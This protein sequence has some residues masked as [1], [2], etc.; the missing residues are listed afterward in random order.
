M[1]CFFRFRE[2]N[3]FTWRK[4]SLLK[5]GIDSPIP[6]YVS[7]ED[8]DEVEEFYEEEIAKTNSR[9]KNLQNTIDAGAQIMEKK[10]QG[11]K[12]L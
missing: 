9:M 12:K 5:I 3:C 10:I 2:N 6:S 1:F 11:T 4:D 8:A 7:T